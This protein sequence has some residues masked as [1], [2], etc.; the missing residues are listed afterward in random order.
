ME[1]RFKTFSDLPQELRDEVV[2]F[3][4]ESVDY[5]KTCALVHR[6]LRHRAQSHFFKSVDLSTLDRVVRLVEIIDNNSQIAQ[7]ISDI[8]TTF[9]GAVREEDIDTSLAFLLSL[10]KQSTPVRKSFLRITI[11]ENLFNKPFATEPYKNRITNA[12]ITQSLACVTHLCLQD[13]LY[14][15]NILLRRFQNLTHLTSINSQFDL[16]LYFLDKPK[17]SNLFASITDIQIERTDQFPS[18]LIS[19]CPRLSRLS[20]DQVTFYP[21]QIA[22]APTVF[23]SFPKITRLEFRR[24]NFATI[25]ALGQSIVDLT[26]LHYVSDCADSSRGGNKTD[27]EIECRDHIMQ[28]SKTSL[29]DT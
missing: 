19:S 26:G 17:Q 20:I 22:V 24:C 3:G 14:F 10:I 2:G 1:N 5:L 18:F 29:Q 7:Y 15:P 6:S 8:A 16:E 9:A 4:R 13:I 25:L 28:L 11:N 21:S 27:E 12:E 23:P